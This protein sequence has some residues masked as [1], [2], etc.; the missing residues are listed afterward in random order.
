MDI[1]QIIFEFMSF[2]DI[3]HF[4]S[5]SKKC[6]Y[7]WEN[8]KHISLKGRCH[9][10]LSSERNKEADNI[11]DI[12]NI[13]KKA[14]NIYKLH[15]GFFEPATEEILKNIPSSVKILKIRFCKKLKTGLHYLPKNIIELKIVGGG[16]AEDYAFRDDTVLIHLC[17]TN[18]ETLLLH[19]CICYYSILQGLPLTLKTLS[20]RNCKNIDKSLGYLSRMENIINISLH[21][22]QEISDEELK[23][24]PQSIKIIDLSFCNK[25]TNDGLKNLPKNIEKM[26]ISNCCL[27][28]DE[29]IINLPMNLTYL[30][31]CNCNKITGKGLKHLPKNIEYLNLTECYRMNDEGM[32]NLPLNIKTL[33]I[34]RCYNIT[35]NGLKSI[36]K[37]IRYIDMTGSASERLTIYTIHQLLLNGVKISTK[38]FYSYNLTEAFRKFNVMMSN[39]VEISTYYDSTTKLEHISTSGSIREHI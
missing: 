13:L 15:I 14:T 34:R 35:D 32:E 28:S 24:L 6:Q 3:K 7:L 2:Y 17:D 18:I 9:Y 10:S 27:I 8:I 5:T 26:D 30:S 12:I 38:L 29:G 33:I 21:N 39:D 22:C 4:L 37:S 25:I 16:S 23:Y 11:K 31:I 1:W 36:P 19:N 20:L